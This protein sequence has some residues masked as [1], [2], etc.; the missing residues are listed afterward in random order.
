MTAQTSTLDAELALQDR[1]LPGVSRTFA[2]TI[3]ELPGQLRTAVTNAYLLC[4]IADTI[5]DDPLLDVDSKQQF[6]VDFV[7]VVDGNMEPAELVRTLAPALAGGT[8]AEEVE[9]VRELPSIVRVTES[10]PELSRNAV[11]RCLRIMC[12][13]MSLR[14]GLCRMRVTSG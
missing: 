10:L 8:P 4:R 13:G 1:L 9:L 7:A 2:L 6:H 11:R 14:R 12:S 3:P 5:E